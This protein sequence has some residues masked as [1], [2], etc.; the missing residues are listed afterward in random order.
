MLK[1]KKVFAM[2]CCALFL[3][4]TAGISLAAEKV[5]PG[6][7]A[8]SDK[9]MKYPDAEAFCKQKGGKLLRI[10]KS[11][12][13][14]GKKQKEA[15]VDG[16]ARIPNGVA[17][18]IAWPAGINGDEA[19]WT[20]TRDAGNPDFIWYVKKRSTDGEVNFDKVIHR[21]QLFVICVP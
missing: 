13:W 18:G 12:S 20:A 7:V 11:D 19:Y 2:L 8:V 6:F 1:R 5:P 16:F 9:K 17:T 14:D 15:S 21:T 10:N 3:F 4:V